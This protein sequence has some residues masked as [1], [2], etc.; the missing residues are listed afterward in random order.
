[1]NAA[2][3]DKADLLRRLPGVDRV[4]AVLET[5]AAVRGIPRSVLTNAIRSTLETLRAQIMR[6][7]SPLDPQALDAASVARQAARQAGSQ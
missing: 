6:G 4:L 2:D 7:G 3:P 1:M 5:K